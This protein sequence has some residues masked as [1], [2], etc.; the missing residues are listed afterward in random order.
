[1][2]QRVASIVA[3][4]LFAVSGLARA[5]EDE[6]AIAGPGAELLASLAALESHIRGEAELDAE[7]IEAHKLTIDEHREVFGAS[8]ATIK[9]SLDLV[10]T[11]DEVEGPLWVARGGFNRRGNPPANDIHWT[12]YNVMQ[13]I[14]DEVY[15]AENLVRYEDLLKGFKFGSSAHFPG[16]VEP[17]ADP[18]AAYTVKINGSY[19]KPFK[20][21]IM[22]EERPARRPTGAYVAPGTIATVV[23]PPSMVGK[24]Y[25]VRVGAHSWDNSRKP[26]VLRL[27][28][29]SLVY[30]IDSSE[31]KVASPLG[32]GIYVEVP[33]K[34]DAGIVE[35]TVKNAVR[36]PYFS[37][38][39]F[40]R[41]SLEEWRNVE[42]H[43][44]APWADFQSEKFMMQVPTS[45]IY[46]LDDPVTLM[47]NWDAAMDAMNDLMGLPRV[48]GKETMYLQVDLQNR[49]SVFAPG[50]P[51]VNDRYDPK[52][53]YDGYVDHYLVRGPQYAPDYVFHEQ[54][55]GY[56]FVKFGGE[57]ESTVNLLH[58]A[59]WHQKFGYSLDE[60]FRA[61]RNFSRNQHR[62]LDNT[63]VTWMTSL[64][65]AAKRPMAAGEKAYQLKGHA[66]FVDIARLFGW[67]V[68]GDFWKSW[69]DDFEAGRPW[70]KH[71]TDI[72]K[73][74]LRL[75]QKAGVDLTPLLHF[76][77]TPPRDPE[78]LRAA[79]AAEKLPAS[80]KVYDALAHY[81]S[82]VPEDN[83]AFRE[84][85]LKWWGK[86]PS[87]EGYWTER[88][89]AK[90]W[91]EFSEETSAQIKQVVQEII[92]TYFPDGRPQG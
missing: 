40:H 19:L 57:Q 83:Q 10:A 44:Q 2:T 39:P 59:V 92:D 37:A 84:F 49:A 82:L 53:E 36:S 15:T 55:H 5:A 11:Y 29:S 47:K 38:K 3:A 22:H 9:A 86:Q 20:H 52:K 58:V 60:A 89:H 48:W 30:S 46:R 8:E 28:R 1:M 67:E 26:R 42:R 21:V 51:T 45:W 65:F 33:M 77:G 13:N 62:T 80:A 68:L 88:E 74:S 66:K 73:L 35:V 4:A 27:D 12:I 43:R 16:A 7:Q 79:I 50:Y 63:A 23:V 54:G 69:V 87:S 31:V 17:P 24:G 71:G 34:A 91:E 25:Q 64:S 14:M 70:S 78:A 76:W 18:N 56:L 75:S 72:D 6:G 41:T 61:S 90:Q 81:K 85:A 32:G